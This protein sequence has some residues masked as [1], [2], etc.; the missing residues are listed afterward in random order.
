MLTLSLAMQ[1]WQED[2]VYIDATGRIIKSN[3]TQFYAYELMVRN[4]IKRKQ[5][6]LDLI[7]S[8]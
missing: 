4:A 1:R 8:I 7:L 3:G 2:I 6:Y 5:F